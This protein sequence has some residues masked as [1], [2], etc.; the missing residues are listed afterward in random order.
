MS[1][2]GG[3]LGSVIGPYAKLGFGNGHVF[4]TNLGEHSLRVPSMMALTFKQR[5]VADLV[6]AIR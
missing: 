1:K 5:R 2:L 4:F 3:V 6:G